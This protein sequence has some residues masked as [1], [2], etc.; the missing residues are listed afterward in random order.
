M[1]AKSRA[2]FINSVASGAIIPCPKC[3]TGNTSDSRF[4]IYCGTEIAA[5]KST[6]NTQASAPA[7][8]PISDAEDECVCDVDTSDD[9]EN[10]Y[11]SDDRYVEPNNVFAQGLPDWTIEP[12]QVM[13]RR[14]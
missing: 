1:D 8:A 4:C 7:F 6:Q 2:N 9:V 14:S 13:V 3:G 10:V 12:P 5:Y 11:V